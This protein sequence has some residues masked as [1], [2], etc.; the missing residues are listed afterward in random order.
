MITVYL[1]NKDKIKE[2]FYNNIKKYYQN[3]QY[4]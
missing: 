2:D 4:L 1:L 3:I